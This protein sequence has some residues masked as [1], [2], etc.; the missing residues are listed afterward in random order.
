[1]DPLFTVI[2][3]AAQKIQGTSYRHLVKSETV[4]ELMRF[5]LTQTVSSARISSRD[6]SRGTGSKRDVVL[7]DKLEDLQVCMWESRC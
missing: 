5:G 7:A 1:M 3:L 6:S 2:K 4:S